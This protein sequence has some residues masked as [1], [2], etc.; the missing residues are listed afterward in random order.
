MGNRQKRQYVSLRERENLL[1]QFFDELDEDEEQFLGNDFAG[2]ETVSDNDSIESSEDEHCANNEDGDDVSN[3]TENLDAVDNAII[4]EVEDS[5]QLLKKQKFKNLEE[6]LD[7]N[8]YADLPAQEDFSFNYS[9]AKKT[10]QITWTANP[11]ARNLQHRGTENQ[12]EQ[13]ST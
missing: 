4:R 8:K 9:D 13:Q 5:E 10:K 11:E 3:V 7:E 6:V 2:E 1:Q 12:E